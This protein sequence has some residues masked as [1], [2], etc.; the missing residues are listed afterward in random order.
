[1]AEENQKLVLAI[2]EFLQKST[3]DGSVRDGDK[4]GIGVASK[5]FVSLI[6]RQRPVAAHLRRLRPVKDRCL[7]PPVRDFLCAY[8]RSAVQ[9]IGEAF[10]VNPSDEAQG[11]Q[12]SIKPATL[13]TIF[14]EYLDTKEK[15]ATPQ[16]FRSFRRRKGL[17]N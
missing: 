5:C 9:C 3:A 8:I 17:S 4:Q 2:L 14:D 16:V 15:M 1:M 11:Q 10:G 6:M 13:Q 7:E 12:L